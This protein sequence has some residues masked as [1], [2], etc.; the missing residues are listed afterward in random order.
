MI[1]A[2]REREREREGALLKTRD[3]LIRSN[4]YGRHVEND[5]N[6]GDDAENDRH[7]SKKHTQHTQ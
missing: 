5:R 1:A 3:L 7:P 2:E 6:H 4:S